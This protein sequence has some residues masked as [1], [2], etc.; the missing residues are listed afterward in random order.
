MSLVSRGLQSCALLLRHLTL[1]NID[2][3]GFIV[4]SLVGD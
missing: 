4:P 1:K 3:L 2:T